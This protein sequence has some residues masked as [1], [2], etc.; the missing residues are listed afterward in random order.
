MAEAI[1]IA[2]AT[3]AFLQAIKAAYVTIE[4]ITDLPKQFDKFKSDLPLLEKILIGA[5]DRLTH[6]KSGLYKED[7]SPILSTLNGCKTRHETLKEIFSHLEK[8]CKRQPESRSW[9]LNQGPRTWYIWILKTTNAPKVERLVDEILDD[10]QKLVNYQI[11]EGLATK[12]DIEVLAKSRADLSE[13][14]PSVEDAELAPPPG[15]TAS[16]TGDHSQL[17]VATGDH[18]NFNNNENTDGGKFPGNFY[19]AF[20]YGKQS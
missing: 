12:T 14:G 15:I 9:N 7:Q 13:M 17:N 5:R 16:Q 6:E 10:I 11:F 3:I 18:N 2:A 8:E 1:G 20:H 19:G 4:S